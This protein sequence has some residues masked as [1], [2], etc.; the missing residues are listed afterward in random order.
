MDPPPSP[1]T[2]YIGMYPMYPKHV[3]RPLDLTETPFDSFSNIFSS[4][5]FSWSNSALS[6]F[7]IPRNDS[8]SAV[9]GATRHTPATLPPLYTQCTLP[10]S[11]EATE[12]R[13]YHS[14]SSPLATPPLP[15]G[16]PSLMQTAFFLRGFQMPHVLYLATLTHTFTTPHLPHPRH[17]ATTTTTTTTFAKYCAGKTSSRGGK[18]SK[19]AP[20]CYKYNMSIQ[21]QHSAATK[22]RLANPETPVT[23]PRQKK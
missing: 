11:R 3:A 2:V 14:P 1:P 18:N 22:K 21:H 17:K 13:A 23:R 9:A 16:H 7:D 15:Q 5:F 19:Q 12:N 8:L 10:Q 20:P 6:R 4:H